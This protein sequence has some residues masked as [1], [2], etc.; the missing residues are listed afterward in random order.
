MDDGALSQAA[1]Q[2]A[3]GDRDAFATVVRATQSDVMRACIAMVGAADAEDLVQETYLRAYDALPTFAGQSQVRT[4]V[5]GIARHVCIDEVR[6][7]TRRRSLLHR[8]P[9]RSEQQHEAAATDISL[10][11]RSLPDD[12][13][14]AF[15]LTQVVGLSYAEAATACECPVGTIRSRVARA[16]AA[17]ISGLEESTQTG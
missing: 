9:A 2:A 4:W 15:V 13:R 7:R 3:A 12:Q 5:L 6:R 8:L 14:E 1:R 17:L 16:R 10:L 11:V